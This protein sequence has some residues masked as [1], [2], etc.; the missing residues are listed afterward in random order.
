MGEMAGNEDTFAANYHDLFGHARRAAHRLLVNADAAEEVA[1]EAMA[2]LWVHWPT[3]A[4]GNPAGW[5]GTVA[6]NLALDALRAKKRVSE[7]NDDDAQQS[8]ASAGNAVRDA[9]IDALA[10]LP[11]RQRSVIVMRHLVGLSAEETARE[12][13]VA[14]PT[15]SVHLHRAQQALRQRLAADA[16]SPSVIKERITMTITSIDAA[17]AAM[18]AR[19]VIT[20]RVTALAKG[21]LTVDIGIPGFLPASLIDMHQVNDLTPYVGRDLDVVVT[22]IG[23]RDN[24]TPIL[25]RRDAVE[26]DDDRRRRRT[27]LERLDVGQQR[28]ATVSQVVGFGV[29]VDLGHGIRALAHNSAL[30][31]LE[32]TIGDT[33]EVVIDAISVDDERVSVSPCP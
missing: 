3:V 33:F 14:R 29:F 32:P 7:H 21:G 10:S 22:G 5:V 13:G 2:R 25:S 31:D 18:E 8:D 16:I 11:E 20:G 9:L 4:G 17:R 26:T 30:G 15:V 23:G 27:A 28:T 6:A 1:A 19:A 12:L 24:D